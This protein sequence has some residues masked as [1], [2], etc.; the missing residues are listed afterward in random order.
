MSGAA[1]GLLA[2]GLAA[3]ACGPTPGAPHAAAPSP[4][5]HATAD[6]AAEAAPAGKPDRDG[7]QIADACDRCP[8]QRETFQGCDDLDGCPDSSAACHRYR[9]N[10]S[11]AQP[12]ATPL[13][14]RCVDGDLPRE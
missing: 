11:A 4:P 7:D 14:P 1:A 8:D 13:D 2:F 6:A 5:S 9:S 12:E 3:I 10:I